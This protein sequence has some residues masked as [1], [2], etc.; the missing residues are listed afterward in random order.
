MQEGPETLVQERPEPQKT[1][2]NRP[3]RCNSLLLLWGNW[4]S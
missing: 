2:T 1:Q 3:N 4:G